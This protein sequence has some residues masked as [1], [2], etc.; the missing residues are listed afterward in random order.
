MT[1][2]RKLSPAFDLLRYLVLLL[3]IVGF[4]VALAG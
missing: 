1:D 3:A 4:I 2:M